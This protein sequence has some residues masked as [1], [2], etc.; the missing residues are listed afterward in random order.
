[1]NHTDLSV[2]IKTIKEICENLYGTPEAM[3]SIL[4][5]G[6]TSHEVRQEILNKITDADMKKMKYLDMAAYILD[7]SIGT[8]IS[9]N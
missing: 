7:T 1:M 6:K 9:F 4:V 3:N 5:R 2:I 8:L